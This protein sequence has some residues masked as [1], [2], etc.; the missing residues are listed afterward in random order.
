M[1]FQAMLWA[2]GAVDG[3]PAPHP[4]RGAAGAAGGRGSDPRQLP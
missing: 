2:L 1:Y 4:M 3:E